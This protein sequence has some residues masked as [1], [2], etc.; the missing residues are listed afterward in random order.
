MFISKLVCDK[1]GTEANIS[2]KFCRECGTQGRSLGSTQGGSV[3]AKDFHD[4]L[5]KLKKP[6]TS[7][8]RCRTCG[9]VI[10]KDGHACSGLI[11]VGKELEVR[12]ATTGK[13]I[14]VDMPDGWGWDTNK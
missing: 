3:S 13:T 4:M 12:Y 6:V 8:L 7:T 9:R 2:D 1:C 10:S 14:G 5:D 11:P